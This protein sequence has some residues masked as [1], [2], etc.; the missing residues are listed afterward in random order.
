MPISDIIKKKLAQKRRLYYK[1][2]RKCGSR[3][4]IS[5]KKCRKC[6]NYNL[7]MKNREVGTK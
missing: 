5:A 7:R 3:N 1:I 6:R 2:C 4:D